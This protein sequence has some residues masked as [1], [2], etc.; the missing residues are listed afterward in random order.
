MGLPVEVDDVASRISVL[1]RP[2]LRPA[3]LLLVVAG[4]LG[5]GA[6]T[7]SLGVHDFEQ[8]MAWVA[9]LAGR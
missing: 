6:A 3:P 2:R 1:L 8:A 5:G 7:K 4:L 9:L